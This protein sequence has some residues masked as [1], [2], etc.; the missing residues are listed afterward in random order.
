MQ[1]PYFALARFAAPAAIL[2]FPKPRDDEPLVLAGWHYARGIAYALQGNADTA[3][4]EAVAIDALAARDL[5]A[6]DTAQVPAKSIMEIA[7][8]LVRAKASAAGGK[9]DDAQRHAEAAMATEST[10]PYMEPPYWYMPSSLTLAAI[11]LRRDDARSAIASFEAA[12][13]KAPNSVWA[14]QGLRRAQLASGDTAAATA[15]QQRLDSVSAGTPELPLER[16]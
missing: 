5:S 6:F 7:A 13:S 2:V 8:H 3:E 16:Y 1:A 10:L 15:T 4:T 12:L 9:L 11:Q 14:L